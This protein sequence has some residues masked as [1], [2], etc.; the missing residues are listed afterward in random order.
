LKQQ[1]RPSRDYTG[2]ICAPSEL[3][4]AG[5]RRMDR[6]QDK[7]GVEDI[8]NF[9]GGLMIS[10][11]AAKALRLRNLTH[12]PIGV[13]LIS[14][15]DGRYEVRAP[16]AETKT[17]RGICAVL[18]SSLTRYIDAWLYDKRPRLLAGRLSD[19]MWL[20]PTGLPLDTNAVYRLFCKATLA[21]LGK[22][23]NPHL[24]RRI[25]ATGVA[26]AA[27]E[28]IN[29]VPSLLDHSSDKSEADV[30]NMADRLTASSQMLDILESRRRAAINNLVCKAEE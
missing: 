3:Y 1:A 11:A 9:S 20:D 13:N 30:Y 2:R 12:M 27:P 14:R 22:H 24:A 7:E 6:Y 21:E 18:P 10:L 8:I 25:V 17:H 4:D 16:A 5:L 23:I 29:I 28:L 15:P 26:I 19:A